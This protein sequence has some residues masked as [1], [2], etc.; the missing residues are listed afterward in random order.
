MCLLILSG[1]QKASSATLLAGMY[2]YCHSR[3]PRLED[4]VAKV[5]AKGIYDGN[6]KRNAAF[7]IS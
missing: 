2:I 5:G 6:Q 3:W 7:Y 4:A 1:P